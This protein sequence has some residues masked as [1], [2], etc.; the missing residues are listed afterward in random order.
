LELAEA[1]F[2]AD[3]V[4]LGEDNKGEIDLEDGDDLSSRNWQPKAA[5]G[6]KGD[7]N[8]QLAL[9]ENDLMRRRL[10]VNLMFA[11]IWEELDTTKNKNKEDRIIMSS[12]VSK[13]PLPVD[14]KQ[15]IERLKELAKML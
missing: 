4:N 10:A 8:E 2:K 7:T 5:S 13:Q 6:G 3:L 12:I 9:L 1:F 15:K 14:N 11:R